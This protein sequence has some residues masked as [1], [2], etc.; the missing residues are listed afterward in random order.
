MFLV[1]QLTEPDVAGATLYHY[2]VD[3]DR[4]FD[5]ICE[6]DGLQESPD[7][8]VEAPGTL[9][10][11]GDDVV[12]VQL[13][14]IEPESPYPTIFYRGSPSDLATDAV[15]MLKDMDEAKA[16]LDQFTRKLYER[17]QEGR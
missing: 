1:I 6:E 15:G 11:A 14:E 3:A 13:F 5:A 10:I 9:R 2:R 4:N 7:V 12:A 17:F 8:S 16:F